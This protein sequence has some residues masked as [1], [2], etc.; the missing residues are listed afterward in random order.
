[1]RTLTDTLEAEQKKPT[2]KPVVK[3][4]VQAYGHPAKATSIQWS[5]FGWQKMGG[6]S[7][8]PNFHGVA[9]PSDGSLNRIKLD[10][11]TLKSQR[12]TSPGPASDYSSWSTRGGV[13]ADSHIAIAA[14]GTQLIIACCSAATLWRFQSSNS[15]ATWGS[16]IEM[17]NA[18]PCERG[19]AV[20]YKSNGDC[21]IVHASDVNDPKSLYLQKRTGGSWSTGLGQRSGDWEI[22]GLAA[23][24]DGD[25]NIIAL[26]L[27]GN[28]LSIVKMIYGDGDKVAAGTWG[29]DEKIGLGRA[30]IDVQAEMLLRKFQTQYWGGA[31]ARHTPTYWEKH[32]AVLETLAGDD[33]GLAGVSLCKPS[34]Y[35]TL[36]SAARSNTPWLFKLS[37]DFIDSNWNK[38]STIPTAAGYGLALAQDG[39]YLWA[40][41]AN[42]VWRTALPSSWTPPTAGSGAGGKIT[43]PVTNILRINE[44]IKPEQQSSLEVELNNSKGTYDSPGTGDLAVMKRGSRVNLHIGYR[45]S[46]DETEE[47]SRY[48]IE[49]IEYNRAP[50][51]ASLTLNCIDAWGLLE[52]YSFNKPVEFNSE[53]DDFTVYALIGKVMD[54]VGGSLS[55][56]SRSTLITSLYPQLNIH[57][58]ESGASVLTRLLNL[59][60]DVIFFFGLAGYIIYPQAGDTAAYK[61]RF[62]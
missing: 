30:R 10:N 36:L 57:A 27:D 59:V 22:E 48:F 21:I 23:Y 13:P 54:A 45:T 7:S 16:A 24:H 6:D 62:P 61:Y 28:Y 46:E 8:T 35:G 44:T 43:I 25:W 53:T 15:G 47:L 2:R 17:S 29:T 55:Y 9:I 20:A 41:Q 38:A 33:S 50:N 32:Q 58:G 26:V 19:C 51:R 5:L 1:M 49:S 11:T 34:D 37:G 12:V 4:E 42:E 40:T 3:V 56:K 14:R 31:A 60:T 39:T 52:R 18:R